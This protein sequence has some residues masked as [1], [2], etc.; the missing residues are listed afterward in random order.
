MQSADDQF[1]EFHTRLCE[2]INHFM[3]IRTRKIPHR[4]RRHEPWLTSGLLISMKKCKNLYKCHVKDRENVPKW[5][6]Y[7][8]YNQ[9]LKK[10]KRRAK[11][12]YY[13]TQC[14]EN[15]SNS[16]KLWRT[17]NQVVRKCNNKTEIIEKLKINNLYEYRGQKI[18]EEFTKYF[19]NI[20]KEYA[21]KMPNPS[22]S[23]KDYL[24]KIPTEPKSIFLKPTTE[25]EISKLIENLPPKKSSGIDGVDNKILKEIKEYIVGP[26]C[27]IFNKSL[28]T[29]IFPE[30]MKTAKVV[31]LYKSKSKD[32]TTNYRPISLL[33]TLS[34]LLEKIMYTRVYSF[35]STNNQLYSSQYGF[36][37]NHACEHAVG[38]L[39]AKVTKGIE[40]GKLTAAIF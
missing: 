17:I 12:H 35:L 21:N 9:E 7:T 27:N 8:A 2:E 24:R 13:T 34:K 40:Q 1:N 25:R 36:R 22:T 31:P 29:G 19:A 26:L 28:E 16:R 32:L 5:L 4:A 39:I 38:E 30:R 20:G 18:V 10:T 14:T 37:K 6:R 15:K 11:I 3:P 33:I 23:L